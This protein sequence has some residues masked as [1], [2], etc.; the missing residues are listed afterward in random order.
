M[1]VRGAEHLSHERLRAALRDGAR[2]CQFDYCL[3][4]VLLTVHRQSDAIFIPADGWAGVRAL[5]YTVITLLAGWWGVPWGL[6]LTPAFVWSNSLG[7]RDITDAVL[8]Q[9]DEGTD[10]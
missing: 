10:S 8:R 5:P 1:T 6:V 7:G 2:V 9:L 4:A 3:S